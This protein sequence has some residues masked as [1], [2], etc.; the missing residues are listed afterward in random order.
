MSTP[1]KLP[2]KKLSHE[3]SQA[4]ILEYVNSKKSQREL[5]NEY[6]VSKTQVQRAIKEW[7]ASKNNLDLEQ[8]KESS[9]HSSIE[10]QTEEDKGEINEPIEI[11]S[12]SDD[13]H[14]SLQNFKNLQELERSN[15]GAKEDKSENTQNDCVEGSEKNFNR[16]IRL[17]QFDLAMDVH[18]QENTFFNG[19]KDNEDQTGISAVLKHELVTETG[20]GHDGAV[21]LVSEEMKFKSYVDWFVSYK[22]NQLDASN[23]D[24]ADLARQLVIERELREISE[25]KLKKSQAEA[26]IFVEAN[27][28]LRS[29]LEKLKLGAEKRKNKICIRCG[30]DSK[31]KFRSLPFCSNDCVKKTINDFT[32]TQ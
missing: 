16:S 29:D 9:N 6:E 13:G 27:R 32:Q 15:H 26:A 30:T 19:S 1:Q 2:R 28:S 11:H 7:K 3:E 12:E 20:A 21:D 17:G 14:E 4:L 31:F 25:E 22:Q 10:R 18:N 24:R 23:I 8:P 5:A